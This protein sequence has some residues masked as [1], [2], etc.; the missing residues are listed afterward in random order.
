LGCGRKS[1]QGLRVEVRSILIFITLFK[2]PM[3]KESN[4]PVQPELGNGS[5]DAVEAP[6]ATTPKAHRRRVQQ[7]TDEIGRLVSNIV[8][9]IVIGWSCFNLVKNVQEIRSAET[10]QASLFPSVVMIV[11][12]CVVPFA[13]GV[14]LLTKKSGKQS[15]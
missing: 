3:N 7:L 15:K 11:L 6:L 8:G 1:R 12:F 5:S 14:F 13:F 10:E 9:C 2:S 4:N